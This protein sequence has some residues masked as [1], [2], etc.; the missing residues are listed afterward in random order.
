MLFFQEIH[1]FLQLGWIGL[2]GNKWAFVTFETTDYK[3]VFHR[4]TNSVIT[5]NNVQESPPSNVGGFLSKGTC[6]SSTQPNRPIWKKNVGFCPLKPVLGRQHS[7]QKPTQF[8]LWNKV[9]YSHA[10]V[11]DGFALG[12]TC[13]LQFRWIGIFG[14]MSVTPPLNPVG[15]I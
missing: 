13:V 15:R 6:V 12:D 8:S 9:L 14:I 3:V 5:E 11:L 1:V 2:F 4:K 10:S 7:F